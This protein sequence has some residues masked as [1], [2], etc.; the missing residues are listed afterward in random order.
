[1][2]LE[3]SM[4]KMMRFLNDHFGTDFVHDFQLAA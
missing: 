3:I 1:M 2:A 4:E